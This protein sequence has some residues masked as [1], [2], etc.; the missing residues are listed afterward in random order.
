[1]FSAKRFF[2]IGRMKIFLPSVFSFFFIHGFSQ[3]DSGSK[4]KPVN[5]KF[6]AG[7]SVGSGIASKY[8]ATIYDGYGLDANAR[9]NNFPNSFMLRRIVVDYGG[10]NGQPD[11]VAQALNVNP[12]EW[13]FDET[14]MP[15]NL[16]YNPVISAGLLLRYAFNEK[17]AIALNALASRLNVNGSFT[18]VVKNPNIGPQ[19]PGYENIQAFPIAGSEQ[20]THIQVG[21]QKILGEEKL[22]F[23]L[24]AGP[25]FT[26]VRFLRN[27]ISINTLHIDLAAYYSY[28]EYAGFREKYLK[29]NGMGGYAGMGLSSEVNEKLTLLL[30]Y[31]PSFEKI[32]MG[33]NPKHTFQHALGLR[34]YYHL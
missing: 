1:M 4:A 32:N 17:N 5:K 20:R 29:G 8:S 21:W 33:E 7:I 27:S 22:K 6:Q 26:S 31:N 11:Q 10:G 28:P 12:G 2:R 16:K 23:I 19:Q 14:D 24:E 25:V 34:V 9:K 30:S 18:I 3:K 15:V 13:S